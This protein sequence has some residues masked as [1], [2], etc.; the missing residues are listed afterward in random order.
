M[1][2]SRH[3]SSLLVFLSSI[4]FTLFVPSQIGS[5]LN[6]EIRDF[7]TESRQIVSNVLQSKVD[8]EKRIRQQVRHIIS[9][10]QNTEEQPSLASTKLTIPSEAVTLPSYSLPP[11]DPSLLPIQRASVLHEGRSD[12]SSWASSTESQ[13]LSL[14]MEEREM[15]RG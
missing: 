2:Y 14:G 9:L 15:V 5:E 3:N 7:Q 10:A 4:T 8:N 11:L 6:Q 1:S 12:R 13:S